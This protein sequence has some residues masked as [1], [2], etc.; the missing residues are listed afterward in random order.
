M[1]SFH[2][3][4]GKNF[5]KKIFLIFISIFFSSLF[6]VQ[7]SYALILTFDDHPNASINSYGSIGTYNNFYFASVTSLYPPAWFDLTNSYDYSSYGTKSGNFAM[8]AGLGTSSIIQ[9]DDIDFYFEG[10][11]VAN[12][13]SSNNNLKIL[14]YN[15]EE[16]VF[17]KIVFI[18]PNDYHEW[19]YIEG[20]SVLLDS[21]TLTYNGGFIVDDLELTIPTLATPE[22]ATIYLF[23]TGLAGIFFIRRTSCKEWQ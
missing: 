9:I 16:L 22:P 3:F 12:G 11:W 21:L 20:Q 18:G 8:S 6:V 2:S 5:F 1:Y 14:G 10:I 13:S 23:F 15:N 17:Q 19:I 4:F 7:L